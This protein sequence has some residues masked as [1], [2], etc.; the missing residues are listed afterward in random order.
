MT[1]RPMS[2]EDAIPYMAQIVAAQLGSTPTSADALPALIRSV[3][4]AILELAKEPPLAFVH[5]AAD[6][7]MPP[8]ERVELTVHHEH[9][10]CLECGRPI[11]LLKSHLR[12]THDLE[13]DEYLARWRLPHDYPTTPEAYVEKRRAVAN[14]IG[15][16]RHGGTRSVAKPAEPKPEQPKRPRGRPRKHPLPVTTNS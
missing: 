11:K 15:L 12:D 7:A 6:P 10:D 13:L 4:D 9:L 3:H 16:G 1:D 2:R 14:R 8:A 5:P